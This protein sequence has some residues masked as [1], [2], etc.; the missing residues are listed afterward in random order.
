MQ[1]LVLTRALNTRPKVKRLLEQTPGGRNPYD[2][3]VFID[4]NDDVRIIGDDIERRFGNVVVPRPPACVFP[5]P[6]GEKAAK[7]YV[8][9]YNI[10]IL[11]TTGRVYATGNNTEGNCALPAGSGVV[12]VSVPTLTAI[13][14]CQKVII[15]T[16][17]NATYTAMFLNY[18]GQLYAAGH[19]QFG[20]IGDGTTTNTG[21]TGPKLSLGPGN[22]YGNPTVTVVDAV[23][24]G[25]YSTE[26]WQTFCALLSDGT[27]WSVGFGRHGQIGNGTSA[28]INNTWKQV[29]NQATSTALTNIVRIFGCGR[30]GGSS[31]YAL[32]SSGNLYGWGW[33]SEGQLA[34]GSTTTTTRATLAST[35]VLDA[36]PF[37]AIY[38]SLIVKKTDNLFY[39]AGHNL[40]GQLG[41]GD[42]VNKTSLTLISSL[43]N[44]NIEQIF[45]GSGNAP[46]VFAKAAGTNQIYAT[47]Y[48][49]YGN[50]GN[51]TVTTPV[52]TF[53]EIPFN[54]TSPIID[55]M[56]ITTEAVGSYTLILTADGNTYFAGQSKWSYVGAPDRNE[57]IFRK[58]T[59]YIVGT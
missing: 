16:G 31:F 51:Y 41:V 27:V 6:S 29:Q 24:V 39:A 26:V 10:F 7:V 17:R 55:I 36:W 56:P 8:T 18:S 11:T 19:N 50:I 47:G 42:T 32:D 40:Y 13:S 58:N 21:N 59:K 4:D 9:V 25:G 54:V 37:N 3:L 23:G 49:G 30:H 33:N 52:T 20:Q 53:T 22:P 28:D 48:N 45:I 38:G 44:K 46:C 1:K 2:C 43:S 35:N 14:D 12:D 34:I 5:L 57:T 15:S